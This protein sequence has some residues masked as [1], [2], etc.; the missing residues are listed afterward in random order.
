MESNKEKD[1]PKWQVVV[2]G[3]LVIVLSCAFLGYA[4]FREVAFIKFLI[5][6]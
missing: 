3:I 1:I 4:I 5:A 6:K 2:I